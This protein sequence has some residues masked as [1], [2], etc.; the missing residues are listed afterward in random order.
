MGLR[1]PL[2]LTQKGR[3]KHRAMRPNGMDVL[4]QTKR[5][6]S[7]GRD[8]AR[9]LAFDAGSGRRPLHQEET[10]APHKMRGGSSGHACHEID[11][12]QGVS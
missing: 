8:V 4:R 12:N 9:A 11:L 3:W 10:Y 2:T 1:E 7:C 5:Y 6:D